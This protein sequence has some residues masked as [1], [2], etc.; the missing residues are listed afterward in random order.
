[1][2]TE[3]PETRPKFADKHPRLSIDRTKLSWKSVALI[4]APLAVG[5]VV[6]YFIRAKLMESG[7]IFR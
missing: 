7:F 4:C 3:M 2:D 5:G 6:F 1:M